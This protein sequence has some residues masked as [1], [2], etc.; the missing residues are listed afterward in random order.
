MTKKTET[1][2]AATITAEN[3]KPSIVEEQYEWGKDLL[4]RL[5]IPKKK[6]GTQHEFFSVLKNLKNMAIIA[7]ENEAKALEQLND[8]LSP[9]TLGT[10]L[11]TAERI[12]IEFLKG[13][14]AKHD[15]KYVQGE[16]LEGAVA[17]IESGSFEDG[18]NIPACWPFPIK[19]F[20]PT[21]G[22]R[23]RELA[24]AGA[25]IASEI[26]RISYAAKMEGNNEN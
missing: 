15:Q 17:Y 11:I 14:D 18:Q 26:D 3:L 9:F 6:A 25:F 22:D 24:K 1:P 12:R 19:D 8:G 21:P 4:L 5:T 10:Q 16:L 2:E 23:I 20:K 7:M 13:Y